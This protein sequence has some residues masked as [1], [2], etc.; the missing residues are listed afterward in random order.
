MTSHRLNLLIVLQLTLIFCLAAA[1]ADSSA[2]NDK[3]WQEEIARIENYIKIFMEKYNVPGLSIAIYK[4]EF[5][6][7]EG[8]GYADLENSVPATAETTYSLASITKPMTA[9]AIM[10]L[11]V[12]GKLHLDDEVQ[13][14]VPYFPKK[15]HP[16]TI[17]QLLGHLGGISH[18]TV[19]KKEFLG[20]ELVGH[21][22]V[23]HSTEEA[24]AIFKYLD[25]V[26]EPGTRFH[27]SS[28][29][30]N[31]L[32]AAIEGA[33]GKSYAEYMTEEIWVPLGMYDTRVDN[34][35]DLIPHRARGYALAGG[36][37][38]NAE[39]RDVSTC[40]ASGGA[41]SN[42]RDLVLFAKGLD[43]G[44]VLSHEAQKEMYDSMI[45]S[46]GE[47]T[48][49]G[50][51]WGTF[52]YGGYWY[53]HHGGGHEGTAT[54][55]L[56]FPW[57]R[58]AVGITC[59][60]QDAQPREVADYV[61][62]QFLHAYRFR[63]E[64]GSQAGNIVADT[65]HYIWNMGLGHYNR[66]RSPMSDDNETVRAAFA[67]INEILEGS[68]V[69]KLIQEGKPT[70]FHAAAN[71]SE[72]S[73]CFYVVGSYMADRLCDA[74]GEDRLAFYRSGNGLPF[75]QEYIELYKA[76][77][78]IPPGCRFTEEL[79][80]SIAVWAMS[81]DQVW[82]DDVKEMLFSS[83]E[84]S[85]IHLSDLQQAFEGRAIYPSLSYNIISAAYR[86][87]RRGELD[88]GIALLLAGSKLYP[89]D[90][91]T[92]DSLGEF[93]SEKGDKENAVRYYKLALERNPDFPS[94]KK[95]LDELQKA[96]E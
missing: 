75:F 95:A 59:N 12:E 91:N 13:K 45:T 51:G 52:C 67:K 73:D 16:I 31:L 93:Y 53:V 7:T 15:D 25:L 23:H 60:Q 96:P 22:A 24:I 14:Y 56:R 42:A 72:L 32:G 5:L 43:E 46:S 21:L 50:M 70:V 62:A 38:K 84:E 49:Y 47:V 27:Y 48:D 71:I 9:V 58:F 65:L 11:A 69:D 29:G 36:E 94:A 76:D 26:A 66:F 30:Y 20:P 82:A 88:K 63:T 19:N 87:K 79:E 35:D 74:Y 78:L 34:P 44:R 85:Y 90:A 57:E 81:W 4:D 28:Y 39:F 6:W 2:V 55:L 17:R 68:A 37:I 86:F 77:R 61:S 8:Y 83:D 40:F 1:I 92:F 3:G 80:N 89:N 10:R 33:S 41:H 18:Y 64:T 54:I